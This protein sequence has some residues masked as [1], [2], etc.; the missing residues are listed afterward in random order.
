MT[1]K[2]LNMCSTRVDLKL[3]LGDRRRKRESTIRL[4]HSNREVSRDSDG[5]GYQQSRIAFGR[6]QTDE[7]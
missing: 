4:R 6:T 7:D 1:E 5:Q 2:V 3:T